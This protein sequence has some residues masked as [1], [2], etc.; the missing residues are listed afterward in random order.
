MQRRSTDGSFRTPESSRK[1]RG[2]FF[3]DESDRDVGDVRRQREVKSQRRHD[4]R[5]GDLY[6]EATY[7]PRKP[8]QRFASRKYGNGGVQRRHDWVQKTETPYLS[9]R[10]EV[11]ENEMPPLPSKLVNANDD[12]RDINVRGAD[13]VSGVVSES[14][15]YGDTSVEALSVTAKTVSSAPGDRRNG[16]KKG[17]RG[18][19]RGDADYINTD[20]YDGSGAKQKPKNGGGASS[21]NAEKR[22]GN[23]TNANG[24]TAK[25]YSNCRTNSVREP[26]LNA[27]GAASL[28]AKTKI[29]REDKKGA[30]IHS[31]R[32]LGGAFGDE[33]TF[34]GILPADASLEKLEKE[35]G[36]GYATY[37]AN[38]VPMGEEIIES[39]SSSSVV[40][41]PA[42]EFRLRSPGEG[43]G[44][45]ASVG[46]GKLKK[47]AAKGTSASA[48]ESFVEKR[49][50]E[51][52]SCR[53]NGQ[54]TLPIEEP[55]VVPA[56][57]VES[58][59]TT[60]YP[61]SKNGQDSYYGRGVEATARSGRRRRSD[62]DSKVPAEVYEGFDVTDDEIRCLLDSKSR[63]GSGRKTE[64]TSE[65]KTASSGFP[66][67]LPYSSSGSGKKD[68][69]RLVLKM[70]RAK[71]SDME[72]TE[73]DDDYDRDVTIKSGRTGGSVKLSSHGRGGSSSDSFEV[74]GRKDDLRIELRR[75]HPIG[76]AGGRLVRESTR[77]ERKFV[78]YS[79]RETEG[80]YVTAGCGDECASSLGE[81]QSW[82]TVS[83]DGSFRGKDRRRLVDNVDNVDVECRRK[84]QP[85]SLSQ[86]PAGALRRRG[87]PEVMHQE[88]AIWP[89]LGSDSPLMGD[90]RSRSNI[91]LR[92][93]TSSLHVGLRSLNQATEIQAERPVLVVLGGINPEDPMREDLGSAV[94]RYL[95]DGDQWQLCCFMPQAR[96]YHTTAY[97]G[98]CIY[99][100]GGFNL[101]ALDY[102]GPHAVRLLLLP[103]HG[104]DD[105]EQVITDTVEYFDVDT[106]C[107]RSVPSLPRPLMASAAAYFESRIWILGGVTY[108]T[109]VT[110]VVFEFDL[111]GRP[112]I[113]HKFMAFGRS[114]F[115][116]VD[117][118]MP[119][120]YS[121][122][123]TTVDSSSGEQRLWLWGGMDGNGRSVGELRWWKPDRRAWKSYFLLQHPRHA[124]CG[125]AIGDLMC[126]VGG[127]ESRSSPAA[128]DANTHVDVAVREVH[129]A[130]SLP[131]PLTGSSALAVPGLE[132][133]SS[134]RTAKQS[135]QESTDGSA[136]KMRT[137]YRR[138]R[139][140]VR[141]KDEDEWTDSQFPAA[142][143]YETTKILESTFDSSRIR[144]QE[145]SREK[146]PTHGTKEER[147]AL[148]LRDDSRQRRKDLE[149]KREARRSEGAGRRHSYQILAPSVDPNLGL[150]LVLGDDDKTCSAPYSETA[151]VIDS[152]RRCKKVTSSKTWGVLSFGGMDL[153]R[154]ACHGTGQ[155]VLYFGALKNAWEMLDP[156]PEP[157]NYH[158][159]S[160]VGD[161]VFIGGCDPGRT[162]CDEMVASDSVFCFSTG[163]KSWTEKA[164]LPESRA[165]HGAA[166]VGDQVYV[167]GG[168][169]QN[170]SYLDTV[171]VYS[172]I[173]NAW[174]VVLKLP[175]AL[176]G[177]AVVAHE[178]RIWVL[179]GVAFE[180]DTASANS[181]KERLL[182][183]VFIVDTRLRRCSKGPSLPFPRAFGAG[184]VCASQIWLCGGLTPSENGKLVSTSNIHVLED[185]AWVFYDV[186]ALNRH[187]LAATS[188]GRTSLRKRTL[189]QP[190]PET[191]AT[192]STQANADQDVTLA[193]I[194]SALFGLS[195]NCALYAVVYTAAAS[196]CVDGG[197][198]GGFVRRSTRSQEHRRA[199]GEAHARVLSY[200]RCFA[201]GVFL[202][203]L[204]LGMMPAVRSAV[205]A[206]Q[207]K[208][209]A[210]RGAFPIAEALVF[211][212]FCATVCFEGLIIATTRIGTSTSSSAAPRESPEAPRAEPA[213]PSTD[214]D[215]VDSRDNSRTRLLREDSPRRNRQHVRFA[216]ATSSQRGTVAAVP[217]SPSLDAKDAER[218]SAACRL[219][220]MVGSVTVHSVLEGISLGLQVNAVK[221][222]WLVVGLYMHKTLMTAAVALDAAAMEHGSV[223]SASA[224][225]VVASAVPAGQMAALLV[226]RPIETLTKAFVQA[227]STGTFFHVTLSEVLPPELNRQQDRIFKVTFMI[228]GFALVAT[229]NITSNHM[230]LAYA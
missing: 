182:D 33:R 107:W 2:D 126:I 76:A 125:A 52:R 71:D 221:L 183:D 226:G 128:S 212:G 19:C 91:L 108:S 87:H 78:S 12:K 229:A 180:K 189:D 75:E 54:K 184:A 64:R 211:V 49:A 115:R 213:S 73:D 6:D 230:A 148:E 77:V 18:P 62:D 7:V 140:R 88:V 47:V 214:S 135:D 35:A 205:Q 134:F 196:P 114:W 181:A 127:T 136:Y 99:V 166:V 130:R 72:L 74:D 186:L 66:S 132:R 34:D 203:T 58:M 193:Q 191:M 1:S 118:W 89:T 83:T 10:A 119:L 26:E 39:S 208:H 210:V 31:P 164:K 94:L 216:V 158:T 138:Y 86:V 15:Y 45:A 80:E 9:Y 198:L 25:G 199:R 188:Y 13:A 55:V 38:A 67:L 11:Q 218:I 219:G 202:A 106:V 206:A 96:S 185:G 139:Q 129:T 105:V 176:M 163:Q 110:D 154:P 156:M 167:V 59:A 104:E 30:G 27:S 192:Q 28:Q 36:L 162:L 159:A 161:E 60:A 32:T 16:G 142:G 69:A 17:E 117:L 175:V 165:F 149:K 123:L 97:V 133:P 190:L 207:E 122:A 50:T 178:G 100:F 143:V 177:A 137:V 81:L 70:Q 112:H 146:S 160:L 152:I 79:L 101:N 151:M 150:A 169:D 155:L 24:N 172:P 90:F 5:Y 141:V 8:D 171:A 29:K 187:A 22:N 61:H 85:A 145:I 200:G 82:S 223:V 173:L 14:S 65:Y 168:R 209:G 215:L 84:E 56:V 113:E 157:R 174:S 179:G 43:R 20:T 40:G 53:P 98:N 57:S 224:G 116:S 44:M 194:Q 124:F 48:E 21:K 153:H 225:L 92:R 121:L 195:L 95:F 68:S 220:F 103:G 63:N 227:L 170:G 37:K 120:A 147:L 204:F 144:R 228:V 42:P 217:S 46:N 201:A 41:L 93:S 3:Y 109:A 4:D 51:Q 131:Y 197:L 111:P 102:Q 23:V 222:V